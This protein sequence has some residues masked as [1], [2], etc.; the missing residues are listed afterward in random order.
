MDI[1]GSLPKDT[2]LVYNGE[3]V[4]IEFKYER[5]FLFCFWCGLL[6][7]IVEDCVDFLEKKGELSDCEFDENLR[8]FPP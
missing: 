6:D 7:H 4:K 1:Q 3:D 8:A 5:L 2:T